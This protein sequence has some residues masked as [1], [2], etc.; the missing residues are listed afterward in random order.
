[1]YCHHPVHVFISQHL[2]RQVTNS[3][4][5]NTVHIFIRSCRVTGKT[6]LNANYFYQMD[7]KLTKANKNQVDRMLTTSSG[8]QVIDDYS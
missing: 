3:F 1:M 7:W 8:H 6:V 4:V 2:V 5:L